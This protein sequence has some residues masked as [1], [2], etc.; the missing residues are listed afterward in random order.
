M[1]RN[2]FALVVHERAEPC[3]LL[4]PVLRQLGVDTYSVGNCE[5]A[6]HLLEQTHPHLVFTDTKLPD[7]SWTD[8][9]NFAEEAAVPVCTILVGNSKNG[10]T[11]QAALN[12]GA[13]DFI[14]PPFEE[15]DI[16][17]LL[18][19][20]MNLVSERRERNLRAAVA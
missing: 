11:F 8:I 4:K 14:S 13:V 15:E 20:A 1:K 16:S 19:H 17:A 9:V 5:E 7:G 2:L 12:Y 18:T 3:E 6:S 10:D